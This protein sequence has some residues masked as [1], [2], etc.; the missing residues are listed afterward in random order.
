MGLAW[1]AMPMQ[2]RQVERERSQAQAENGN[3]ASAE[4]QAANGATQRGPF[5]G[6]NA[7][8]AGNEV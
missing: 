1:R 5:R 3:G 8:K 7:G 4:R 2:E 6:Q